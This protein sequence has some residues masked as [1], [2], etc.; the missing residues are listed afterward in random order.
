MFSPKVLNKNREYV[1]NSYNAAKSNFEGI[2]L[3]KDENSTEQYI[4]PNQQEDAMCISDIFYKNCIGN[5]KYRFQKL[6]DKYTIP[7]NKLIIK[8]T[9]DHFVAQC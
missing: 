1:L 5:N 4:Y 9:R 6:M 2:C 3:R 8:I 7:N